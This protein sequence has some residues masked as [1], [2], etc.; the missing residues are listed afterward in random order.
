[1]IYGNTHIALDLKNEKEEEINKYNAGKSQFGKDCL[2]AKRLIKFGS[3]FVNINFGGWDM[4]NGI[5]DGFNSRGPELDYILSTLISDLKNELPNTLIVVAS[6]FS[7]TFK[8]NQNAGRD[9]MAST[10][11][12]LLAG[13]G[14]SHGKL[15]GDTTADGSQVS[16][17]ELS[18]K[19]L[20]W[21]IF[22]HLGYNK[23]ILLYDQQKRPHR[24]FD[25]QAQDIITL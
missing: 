15:I 6:E 13:G 5:M 21:T 8:I 25:Q 23:D 3:Q 1:M 14:Y 18:P 12:V 17:D 19:D 10:N 9:H 24:M 7:R 11:S 22:N 16:S 2:T 20:S 4:H